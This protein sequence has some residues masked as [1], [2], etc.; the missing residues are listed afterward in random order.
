MID[1]HPNIETALSKDWHLEPRRGVALWFSV[2]KKR[3]RNPLTPIGKSHPFSFDHIAPSR[4]VEQ[5][6]QQ[7]TMQCFLF[8]SLKSQ[9][10]R[11][12]KSGPSHIK[13]HNWQSCFDV[14]GIRI[15]FHGVFTRKSAKN[16]NLRFRSMLLYWWCAG[17]RPSDL[18]EAGVFQSNVQMCKF[19]PPGKFVSTAGDDG[20]EVIGWRLNAVF[21]FY[22]RTHT[23]SGSQISHRVSSRR[24]LSGWNKFIPGTCMK[25]CDNILWIFNDCKTS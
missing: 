10:W 12:G 7:Y 16:A 21:F 3:N 17:V 8:L 19:D 23:E 22:F 18:A 25:I 13:G 9:S 6:Q 4:R 24:S 1:T 2:I 20:D 14:S 15:F 5:Q 11:Q